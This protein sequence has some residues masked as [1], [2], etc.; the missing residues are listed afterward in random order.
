MKGEEIVSKIV[1]RHWEWHFI[2][3][4]DSDIYLM[5]DGMTSLEI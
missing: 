1:G 5:I 2:M 3:L 4:D